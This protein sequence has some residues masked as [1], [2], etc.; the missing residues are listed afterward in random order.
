MGFLK[1]GRFII[2]DIVLASIVWIICGLITASV[3]L[4]VACYVAIEI[5]AF[6]RVFENIDKISAKEFCLVL[7]TGPTRKDGQPNRFFVRRMNAAA[8]LYVKG[9]VHKLILSGDKHD[10]Y[11]EPSAM[12]EALKARGVPAEACCLDGKGYDTIDSI[13]NARNLFGA[14]T[15]IIVSQDFHCERAVFIAG[16]LGIK[17]TAFAAEE[18]EPFWKSRTKVRE[19]VARVKVFTDILQLKLK[20]K[21]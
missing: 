14:Q 13:I 11:D 6:S 16:C 5:Y 4:I 1:V 8:E 12:L 21:V 18:V 9:K 10:G 19:I 2:I 20:T 15:Y 17:A 7:G 3:L